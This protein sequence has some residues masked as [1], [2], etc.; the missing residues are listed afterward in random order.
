VTA[1]G[2]RP[3][4]PR[5]YLVRH[6]ETDWNAAGRLLST[7]DEPLNTRGENQARDLA[8]AMAKIHWDRAISSPLIRARRTAEIL[9]AEHTRPSKLVVDERLVEMDFGHTRVGRR[10]RSRPIPWL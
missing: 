5:L 3:T 7:T 10:Q 2:A 4:W 9:L 6:G 8:V 1:S